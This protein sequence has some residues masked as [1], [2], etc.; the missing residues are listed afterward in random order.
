LPDVAEKQPEVAPYTGRFKKVM[1]AIASK[2]LDSAAREA[3]AWREEEPG[4]VMALVGLGEVME[5]RGD[6]ANAA[7]AYGSIIELFPSR[8]DLRRFAGGRLE[9][10]GDD[11]SLDL[12]IDTF[13]KAVEERPD[14]PSSH[15]MLAYALV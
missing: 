4:D 3:K 1:D 15:R 11:A 12:A 13:T 8:A 7:R 9:H 2:D 6:N 10:I 5:A 14:H